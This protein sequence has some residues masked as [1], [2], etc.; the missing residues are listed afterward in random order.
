MVLERVAMKGNI[1][2]RISDQNL[3][4]DLIL[5]ENIYPVLFTCLDDYKNMYISVC[6][7]A[8]GTKTCWLLTKTDPEKL[9]AL[10]SNKVTIRELFESDELWSVCSTED[11]ENIYVEKIADYRSFD[12]VA[13]PVKG[14]YMD[15][16][17]GEFTEEI[18]V[19]QQRLTSHT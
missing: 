16:D 15:A 2:F 3:Y 8:D 10:L 19:L 4:I 18:S 5:V 6:Y 1:I 11:E 12:P 13:F 9:I 17:S 7:Y 14:E